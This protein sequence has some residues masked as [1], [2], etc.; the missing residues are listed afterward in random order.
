[1]PWIVRVGGT[2]TAGGWRLD[3]EIEHGGAPVE[4]LAAA[5]A[6]DAW[7]TALIGWGLLR[8]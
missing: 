8:R 1:M 2:T 7:R 4:G 5:A 3:V 6:L